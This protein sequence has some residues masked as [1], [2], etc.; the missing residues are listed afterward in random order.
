VVDPNN[1]PDY[2]KVYAFNDTLGSESLTVAGTA[3][4][5]QPTWVPTGM[6]GPK[7]GHMALR[8]QTVSDNY[9]PYIFSITGEPL[10]VDKI[11]DPAHMGTPL[12]SMGWAYVP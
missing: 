3:T 5:E 6:A 8:R 9:P 2:L 1:T 7:D 4:I 12:T 11:A 10:V